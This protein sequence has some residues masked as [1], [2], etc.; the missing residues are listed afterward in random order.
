[1]AMDWL[2]YIGVWQSRKAPRAHDC[3]DP[4]VDDSVT[5][6]NAVG[7]VPQIWS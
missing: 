2:R 4:G 6:G 5:C 7:F 1:L 3:V